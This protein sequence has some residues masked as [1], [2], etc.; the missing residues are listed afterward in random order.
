MPGLHDPGAEHAAERTRA[1]DPPAGPIS[2]AG[3][4]RIR[5]GTA[6]WTDPTL[7][8]P[9]LFYPKGTESPEERLRY[10]ASRFPLVEIDSTYYALPVRRNAELWAARTPPGFVFDV[11]A[12]ALMTGHPTEV[13]R[14]PR[15]L[16]EALPATVAGQQRVYPKDLPRDV[17]DEVWNLFREGI[18]PLLRAGKLGAVLL[19]YPQWFV[20]SAAAR[21]AILESRER[22]GQVRCAIE[23]RNRRWF[24]PSV[25]GRTLAFL[26]DHSLPFVVV[27]EP[28]GLENSV[29]T[30]LAVTAPALAIVRLHG[31]RG[32]TWGKRGAT[33]AE[34][35]RYLY[36]RDELAEWTPRV[37]EVGEQAEDT[38]VV[39]NNCYANYGTTNALEMSALLTAARSAQRADA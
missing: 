27:D 17:Y 4:G 33:V 14:L 26:R 7:L 30:V 29:P 10:Y 19:Q 37:L 15:A 38:H 34:K 21:E 28:Q 6:G 23:F 22:L 35:Y 9:G 8:P 36:D 32:D 20:P 24:A 5:V 39:F 11:K 2:L 25:A 3:G 13:S 12:Y 16:R 18:D 31:R 1:V